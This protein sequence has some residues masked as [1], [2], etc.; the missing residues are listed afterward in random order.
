ME[1]D[2]FSP[3]TN[4]IVPLIVPICSLLW[5]STLASE[6]LHVLQGISP[7]RAVALQHASLTMQFMH[8]VLCWK[9]VLASC[10]T[11]NIYI[12]PASSFQSTLE[13]LHC[14]MKPACTWPVNVHRVSQLTACDLC[15][16]FNGG[17]FHCPW[18]FH[19]SRGSSRDAGMA[20]GA[21]SCWPP[22]Q[23]RCLTS[24]VLSAATSECRSGNSLARPSSAKASSR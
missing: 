13:T 17:S 24:A 8:I 20:S 5:R 14:Y 11:N 4:L 6:L 12:P 21:C 19:D 10:V 22:G 16:Q 15:L 1:I 7:F 2:E 3:L 18:H 23:M 9:N